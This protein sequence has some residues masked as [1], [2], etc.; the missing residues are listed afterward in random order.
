M[1]SQTSG[2]FPLT[3]DPLISGQSG[4]SISRFYYRKH[5]AAMIRAAALLRQPESTHE[6][7]NPWNCGKFNKRFLHELK[8]LIQ[9][10]WN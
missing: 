2:G 8:L 1:K 10:V 6:I 4:N 7:H 3:T 5:K 9:S